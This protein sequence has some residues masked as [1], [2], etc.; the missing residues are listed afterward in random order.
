MA[1]ILKPATPLEPVQW[2][3]GED[4]GVRR[5]NLYAAEVWDRDV[6]GNDGN[7]DALR[8]GLVKFV[9]MV[10]PSKSEEQIK[11]ECSEDFLL[12]VAGYAR[13]R[14]EQATQFLD[15]LSGKAAGA[16]ADPALPA[17]TG[18]SPAESPAPT[19][20]SSGA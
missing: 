18:T 10:C 13:D 11:E 15:E 7:P 17:P 19:V 9:S 14:L 12:L 1:V 20:E 8:A 16:V 4:V 6:V 2:P 5:P 3:T